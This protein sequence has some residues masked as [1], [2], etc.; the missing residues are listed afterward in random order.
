MR[1]MSEELTCW[2]ITP[3]LL[4]HKYIIDALEIIKENPEAKFKLHKKIYPCIAVKNETTSRGV[5]SALRNAV[6]KLPALQNLK[7]LPPIISALVTTGELCTSSFLAALAEY[8]KEVEQNEE[9]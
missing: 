3:N 4:G 2:G 5:G 6:N 7:E 1:K 9:C 8:V